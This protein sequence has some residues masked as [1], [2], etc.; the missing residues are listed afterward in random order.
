MQR[1]AV[2]PMWGEEIPDQI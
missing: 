2:L 1:C